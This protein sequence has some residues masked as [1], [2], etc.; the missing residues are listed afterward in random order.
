MGAVGALTGGVTSIAK[1][2]ISIGGKVVATTTE[3]GLAATMTIGSAGVLEAGGSA[4]KDS[5]SNTS[6]GQL[7]NNA[8]ESGLEAISPTTRVFGKVF[9]EA[10]KNVAE[11]LGIGEKAADVIG[12]ISGTLAEQTMKDS[13]NLVKNEC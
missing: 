11:N 7:V 13:C 8:V 4:V 2:T 5:L 6:S 3:K 9:K 1:S 10:G 12:D